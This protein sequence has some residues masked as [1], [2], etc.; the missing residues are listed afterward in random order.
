MNVLLSPLTV[1]LSIL[2]LVVL[3][4]FQVGYL[5]GIWHERFRSRLP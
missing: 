3:M 2:L 5:A 1:K 4:G